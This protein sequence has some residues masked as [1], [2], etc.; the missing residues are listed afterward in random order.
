M[1]T[2]QALLVAIVVVVGVLGWQTYRHLAMK[3]AAPT[4]LSASV[5]GA[6]ARPAAE[7][8]QALSTEAAPLQVVYTAE[9]LRDPL[10]DRLPQEI[11][12]ISEETKE[13][14]VELPTLHLQGLVYGQLQPRAI[15]DGHVVGEGDRFND[16]E[17]VQI[18]REG[19]LLTYRNRQ[20]FLKAGQKAR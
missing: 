5:T 10:L 17:V 20:F 15:I 6:L 19:V 3:G 2:E 14:A 18:Q 1:K 13:Q 7:A 12:E 16:I 9:G 8:S 4:A 11:Q